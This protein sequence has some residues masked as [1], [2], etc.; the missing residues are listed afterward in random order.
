MKNLIFMN[1][2]SKNKELAISKEIT[3][4]IS[5]FINHIVL[6]KGLSDNTK[7][8]Y[9]HD[10]TVFA[11][12]LSSKKIENFNSVKVIDVTLFIEQLSSLGL[13]SSSRARYLSSLRSLYKFL[14]SNGY[15]DS[16]PTEN[17]DAPKLLRKL[18]EVLSIDDVNSILES[19]PADTLIGIRDRAILET[20]YACGLRVSELCNLKQREII[21]DA[22]IIRVFGKGSKERIIPIGRSAI[23]WIEEYLLKVRHQFLKSYSANDI[24]FLN[25]RG[26]GLSRMWIWKIVDFYSKKAGVQVKCYPHIFRHSFATHLIEGGADLRAVQ[27]MLGH[28]DISTTQIYTHLDKAYIKEVHRTFHPRA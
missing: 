20:L 21:K 15:S 8:S 6:E 12:F 13:S 23:H 22:E 9:H 17:V 10:L 26:K 7:S 3:K 4:N 5:Q 11:E 1:E 27:E 16:D 25:S 18:P 2:L 19:C 24:I 28:S 14:I